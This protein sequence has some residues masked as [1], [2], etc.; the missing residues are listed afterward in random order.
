MD[1]TTPLEDLRFRPAWKCIY[2]GATGKKVRLG[3]EHVIPFSMGGKL[4]LPRASCFECAKKTRDIET[5]IGRKAFGNFR[6]RNRFPTRHPEERPEALPFDAFFENN[7]RRIERRFSSVS[8]HPTTFMMPV[9]GPPGI[10]TN[11]S[12]DQMHSTARWSWWKVE[13]NEVKRLLKTLHDE[14]NGSVWVSFDLDFTIFARFLAKIGPSF[15]PVFS[16]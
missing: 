6:I 16:D 9:Y 7:V 1:Y 13:T 10:L 14:G 3:K 15:P 8:S 5:Y 2:C 4:V 12:P 11:R